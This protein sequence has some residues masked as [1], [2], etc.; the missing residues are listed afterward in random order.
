MCQAHWCKELT[1]RSEQGEV[2][3]LQNFHF[4]EWKKPGSSLKR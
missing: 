4:S 2:S 1:I 3:D